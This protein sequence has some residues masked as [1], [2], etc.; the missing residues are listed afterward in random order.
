MNVMEWTVK[1][2]E[3][4]SHYSETRAIKIVYEGS[5]WYGSVTKFE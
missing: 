5:V 4:D 3:K 1:Q 2:L